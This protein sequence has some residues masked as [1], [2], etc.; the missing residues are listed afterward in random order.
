MS[1]HNEHQNPLHSLTRLM[2]GSLLV[3][4]DELQRQMRVWEEETS[5]LLAEH[6]QTQAAAPVSAED[7]DEDE[8]TI[9]VPPPP[10]PP[11][12]PTAVA[13]Y[14]LLGLIFE[15]QTRMTPQR[16]AGGQHDPVNALAAA[17][18]HTLNASEALKPARQ[19]FDA[20]VTRGEAE[21]ARL[22]A[23]GQTEERHSRALVQTAVSSTVETSIHQIAQNPEI[24]E[25]VQQ[26][27]A[28]LV[29]EVVEEVRERAVSIDTLLDRI[30]RMMF[31]RPPRE[32]L[33]R[34][35][36]ELRKHAA[37]LRPSE[38]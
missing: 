7:E 36:A 1:E 28:D 27:S 5:R 3:A 24:N 33:P 20:W 34:P 15:A 14:A 13:R 26:Q 18:L 31:R 8:D 21:V 35:P 4:Q 38:G 10:P 19:Q 12:T 25:L 9:Y 32:E 22:V 6:Q 2:V 17:V 23:I 16:P 30:A 11:T 29:S 37:Q